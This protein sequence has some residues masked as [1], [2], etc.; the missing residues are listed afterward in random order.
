MPRGQQGRGATRRTRAPIVS[1]RIDVRAGD[2][3]MQHVAA[4]RDFQAR[5]WPFLRRIVN[6]SSSAWVGCSWLPSP[7]VDDGAIDLAPRAV[8]RRRNAG[9]RTTITSRCMA[10][11]VIAVSIRVSPLATEED[12]TDMLMT[13][14]PS[15]LPASS[16]DVRPRRVLEEEVDLGPPAQD[17]PPSSRFWRETS[18]ASSARSSSDDD[19]AGGSGLRCR[20]DGDEGKARACKRHR[21]ARGAPA[22]R[23]AGI[24]T[25]NVAQLPCHR[26]T[27]TRL[28]MAGGRL[29]K[30]SISFSTCFPG[31]EFGLAGPS[32]RPRPRRLDRAAVVCECLANEWRR[33]AAEAAGGARKAARTSA[34]RS[35]DSRTLRSSFCSG[36]LLRQRRCR[37]G[38]GACEARVGPEH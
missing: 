21:P 26:A 10:F 18:T 19:V 2:A 13:S 27:R 11:S 36:E 22:R 16:K 38:E 8:G 12:A 24:R 34:G 32:S 31:D 20:G 5:R 30:L 23:T 7:R 28:M 1:N 37:G 17:R 35:V 6:A 29:K 9:W 3:G 33:A 15:R 4:D 25:E 14:P